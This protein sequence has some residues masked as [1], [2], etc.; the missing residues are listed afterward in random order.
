MTQRAPLMLAIPVLLA[1]AANAEPPK[2]DPHLEA[3]A[4]YVGK[5]WRGEF[6]GSTPEKPQFDVSRWEVALKGKA[7]RTI[8]SVNNGTYGG[9]SLIMWDPK[10]GKLATFYFTTAGFFTEGTIEVRDGKL[11][12]R[13]V[14]RGL[15]PGV[16]E[17]ESVT[18]FRDGK[19]VT[20]ARFLK[21]GKWVDGHEIVYVEAADAKVVID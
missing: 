10:Q 3:F 17:V 12:S 14:V 8:H 19:M 1:A 7:I 15:Q 21:D 18:E 2:L 13:E 6:K 9:E 16:T 4:P 20:K 11:Y 5:T